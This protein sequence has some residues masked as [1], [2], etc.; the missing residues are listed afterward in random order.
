MPDL[1]AAVGVID[2]EAPRNWLVFAQKNLGKFLEDVGNIGIYSENPHDRRKITVSV[3]LDDP[4]NW[5]D[6]SA[7]R[8]LIALIVDG[9]KYKIEI[10]N[11]VMTKLE[12]VL[13][14]VSNDKLA[15]CRHYG[16]RIWLM[17]PD[18]TSLELHSNEIVKTAVA[19]LKIDVGKI[20]FN[21]VD[22]FAKAEMELKGLA[23]DLLAKIRLPQP[24]E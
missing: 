11:P 7:A 18:R 6:S 16:L 9:T 15:Y 23:V 3:L 8:S 12:H 20:N 19:M 2:G 5:K 24:V 21:H 4:G 17:Q 14:L 1:V 13:R 22:S 10:D